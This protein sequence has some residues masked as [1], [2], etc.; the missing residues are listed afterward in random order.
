MNKKDLFELCCPN[1][2][3]KRLRYT[4]INN[5][6]EL[7]FDKALNS[8]TFRNMIT[9]SKCNIDDNLLFNILV[10]NYILYFYNTNRNTD[11]PIMDNFDKSIMDNNFNESYNI[12]INDSNIHELLCII[13]MRELKRSLKEKLDG[14]DKNNFGEIANKIKLL[15]STVLENG[16]VKVN[17]KTYQKISN[18]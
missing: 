5:V 15:N 12:Y 10:K 8:F 1:N 18:R 4:L 3:E 9:L 6:N 14:I 13:Y 2:N 7:G 11:Y 16:K 17:T